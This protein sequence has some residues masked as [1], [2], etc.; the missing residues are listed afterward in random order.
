MN[1][2]ALLDVI[3]ENVESTILIHQMGHRDVIR[4][5]VDEYGT[6]DTNTGSN[7]SD[8]RISVEEKE[9]RKRRKDLKLKLQNAGMDHVQNVYTISRIGES[10][11][12]DL[13][14]KDVQEQQRNRRSP[15]SETDR[16]QRNSE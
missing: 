7:L 16:R 15:G 13:E 4:I 14:V 3:H 9:R 10:D 1:Q 2:Q 8:V 5:D 6:F 11:D 12:K